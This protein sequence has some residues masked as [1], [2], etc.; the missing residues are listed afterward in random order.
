MTDRHGKLS[1]TERQELRNEQLEAEIAVLREKIEQ[2]S[3]IGD[4][5]A[6]LV[7]LSHERQHPAYR[8]W[9]ALRGEGE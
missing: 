3:V 7:E 5:L 8:R 9:Q 4:T 2:M 6:A 1:E